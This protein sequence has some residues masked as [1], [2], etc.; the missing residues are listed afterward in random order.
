MHVSSAKLIINPVAGGGS[1]R[2]QWPKVVRVL[3][4][5]KIPFDCDF[6]KG[7]GHAV[8]LAKKAVTD[9]Y[10]YLIA[11]GGDGT[12]NEVAN[13]ILSSPDP[14]RVKL[15]I[16]KAGTSCGF[17]RSLGSTP[18]QGVFPYKTG[19]V[20]IDVGLVEYSKGRQHMRRFFLNEASAGIGADVV[21]IRRH[22]PNNLGRG[23]NFGLYN[24]AAYG[25]LAFHRNKNVRI[26]IDESVE[27]LRVCY[28][29]MANGQYFA[30][31]M[32]IAPR[33]VLDDGFLNLVTI[34]NV[35]KSELLSI[36]TKAYEGDHIG[37][38]E[39]REREIKVVSIE[40]RDRLFIEA[41]GE[42]LGECPAIF[43]V[44]PSALAVALLELDSVS[45][46]NQEKCS[47]R[48]TS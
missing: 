10:C 45:G 40:C 38:A 18:I 26:T 37:Q 36:A 7:I 44:I 4:T 17:A 42:T 1:T 16:A 43:R 48:F 41:D 12:V 20:T 21:N 19:W 9:G 15:G 39:V 13:G 46:N 2:K 35:T 24:I 22:L 11:V 32:H 30:D 23:V 29:V 34:G 28:I 6:S 27:D 14:E 3:N 25:T 5:A 33:A 31:G 8:E 47:A